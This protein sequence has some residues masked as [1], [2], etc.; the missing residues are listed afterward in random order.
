MAEAKTK[1]VEH[2][3]GEQ[4][5]SKT[6]ASFVMNLFRGEIQTSQLFP[7][8]EPLTAEQKETISMLKDPFEKFFEVC[9]HCIGRAGK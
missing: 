2:K 4:E 9:I 3:V 6:S 5:D 7:F 1:D 8:P